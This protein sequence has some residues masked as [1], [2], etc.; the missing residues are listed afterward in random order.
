[1]KYLLD[2]D[3][4]SELVKGLNATVVERMSSVQISDIALSVVTRG[5]IAFGVQLKAPKSIVRQRLDRLLETIAT[6]PITSDIADHYG[7][8]R[9]RLHQ[10]G[11]PI[12]PNDMWIAGHARALGLTL[13]SNNIK[14]FSRV[15]RLKLESW[16]A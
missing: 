1:M 10:Q 16:G 9:A 7:E 14:E 11:T 15:P 8:L 13:V 3:T 5:E 6:L 4:F 2:T 12:G